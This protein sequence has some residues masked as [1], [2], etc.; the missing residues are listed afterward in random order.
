MAPHS[1]TRRLLAGL[2][3]TLISVAGFSW[4]VRQQIGTLRRLQTDIVDSN[5]K[6]SLQLLRIQNDLNSLAVAMRDMLE[7]AEPYPLTAWRA[8][9]E[10]I[11]VDL[12]DALRIER[13]VAP[14]ARTPEQQ[15]HLA[16]SLSAFWDSTVRM[17]E[18]A[19]QGRDAEARRLLATELRS[20]Q[21]ALVSTVSRLL[22]QNNAAEEQATQ[23]IQEIYHGVER[24][25]YW[26]LIAVLVLIL[27]TSLYVMESNRRIFERMEALSDQRRILAG[28]IIT[29]Q[30]GLFRSVAR[31][32]H[33]EFGQVLAAIGMMLAR[34]EKKGVPA[35][36]PL[37]NELREA[38]ETAQQTLEKIRDLSHSLHPH[39]LD[40]YGLEKTLEWYV[41][42]F[43]K[44]TGIGIR[45]EKQGVG[46]P[47]AVE[48]A[49][50]VYRILQESLNNVA[51]HA[52][53]AQATVRL[54][55]DPGVLHLEVEDQGVGISPDVPSSGL[56]LI[57]MRERAELIHGT[58]QVGPANGRGTLVSLTVPLKEESSA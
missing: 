9:F 23:Q 15:Q 44:Q 35:D 16:N 14:T 49:I 41:A 1:P 37:R 10:R 22:V 18:A 38:R 26:F 29:L 34:A 46:P 33:D 11:R 30:E 13:Q 31:D 3:I 52:Q 55:Q 43:E 50:H 25:I 40:D 57:A 6:G 21:A 36:S 32:L 39:M 56:G 24:N 7:G 5:R 17:F 47:L 48:S 51:R 45:Y 27:A 53:A 8:Q 54:R 28:K 42:L 19:A 2:A 20:R 58:L 4:Y 12:E